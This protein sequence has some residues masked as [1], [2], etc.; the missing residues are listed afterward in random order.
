MWATLAFA[1]SLSLAPAQQPSGQ[2]KLTNDRVTYGALG[3]TRADTKLL[4]GDWFYVMFDIENLAVSKSG[5]VQ[6]SMS[7]ELTNSQGKTEVKKDPQDMEAMA[8]LGGNKM[9]MFA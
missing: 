8:S 4:P 2:L 6:Y 9:P 1:A 7:M 5:K 3:A